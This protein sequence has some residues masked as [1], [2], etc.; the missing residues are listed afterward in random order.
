MQRTN[1]NYIPIIILVLL[2]FFSWIEEVVIGEGYFS[3]YLHNPEHKILRFSIRAIYVLIIFISGYIGLSNLPL[4]WIKSLWVYWY[5]LSFCTAVVRVVLDIYLTR[6]FKTN[7]WSFLG[8]I[9]FSSLTPFPY[10][11]LFVINFVFSR[12]NN[13]KDA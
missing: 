8:T 13:N 9:Y 7:I 11:I 10:I 2:L 5:V 6:Y 12:K 3:D 4:K 1:K